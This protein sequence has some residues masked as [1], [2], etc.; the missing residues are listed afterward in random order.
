MSKK[1]DVTVTA[2]VS[3]G[4]AMRLAAD[5][6]LSYR[7]RAAHVQSIIE[8]HYADLDAATLESNEE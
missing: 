2:K 7:T 1:D 4:I 5:A 6:A 3:K 8:T